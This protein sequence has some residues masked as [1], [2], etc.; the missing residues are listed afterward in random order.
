MANRRL[1][2]LGAAEVVLAQSGR[3]MTA[4][5]IVAEAVRRELLKPA[6]KT[7]EESL[8]AA[9]YVQ[10]QRSDHPRFMRLFEEGRTRARRGS[11]R[12]R[13]ATPLET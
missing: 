3:P 12:W 7:P 4:R 6:G 11:V 8:T 10:A 5:E 13:L 1:T 9:L 2:Y